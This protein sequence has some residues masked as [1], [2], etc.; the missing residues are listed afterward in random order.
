MDT[1][2]DR[3]A[4]AAAD[5]PRPAPR[6]R[7]LDAAL[8]LF[9]QQGYARTSTREIAETAGVNVAAISY[10]FGDK[11]GLYRAAFFEPLCGRAAPLAFD[12][13]T[14]AQ[15]L[16]ALFADLIAPLRAGEASRLCMRLR[17]REMFEPTGLWE[18][19]L[20]RDIAPL[21]AALVGVLQRHLG[22]PAAD[23]EVHRLAIAIVGL[24][25]HLHVGRDCVDLLA[26]ELH[27]GERAL[28][29]WAERLVDYALAMVDAEARRRATGG[30]A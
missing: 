24:G 20:R 23:A 6:Q 15:A 26:P 1:V 17:F 16:G 22:A 28:D 29:D 10:Y 5:A 18:E 30:R 19:E 8:R 21:H 14:L 12:G 25:V 7:L 3:A 27:A 11:A 4:A 13:L 2:P 9:A